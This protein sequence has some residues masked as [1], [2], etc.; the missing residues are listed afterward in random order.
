[1]ITIL[2]TLH[3]QF[4]SSSS[5]IFLFEN[6][7]FIHGDY[8]FAFTIFY[9]SL[10]SI[11]FLLI[12]FFLS[13]ILNFFHLLP[14]FVSFSFTFEISDSWAVFIDAPKISYYFL[15]LFLFPHF[16]CLPF[17]FC[18]FENISYIVLVLVI[19]CTLISFIEFHNF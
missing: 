1:M 14:C 6:I 15:I 10:F 3:F 7:S 8:Q 17:T 18:L 13:M 19:Q 11:Q 16:F 5:F 2:L 9:L 4:S 12:I